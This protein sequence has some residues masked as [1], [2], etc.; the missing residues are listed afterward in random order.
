MKRTAQVA[1]VAALLALPGCDGAGPA[2]RDAGGD[3]TDGGVVLMDGG[4]ETDAGPGTDGGGTDAGDVDG[5]TGTDG[6]T[7]TDACTARTECGRYD[8]GMVDDGCGGTLEC[9]ACALGAPCGDADDCAS[10]FCLTQTDTGWNRGYCSDECFVNADCGAGFHCAFTLTNIDRVG[11]CLVSCGT[12]ADCRGPE[13]TCRQADMDG[14]RECAP[15]GSGTGAIGTPCASNAD[16]AGGDAY[17][18]LL[19]N[20]G[21]RAGLCSRTC[22]V[23]ADCGG[24][25]HCAF[26]PA[27]GGEGAC[28]PNCTADGDC[29][30][31]GYRC[32]NAD[33]DAGGVT[34]CFPSATGA[35]APG[36]ACAGVW[37]CAGGEA[38]SCFTTDIEGGYCLRECDVD[39]DCGSGAH[40]SLF[41]LCLASCTTDGDCRATGYACQ[42]LDEDSRLE[43][44]RAGTGTTAIGAPCESTAECTGGDRALCVRNRNF[45]D[46]FCLQTG[47]T[48]DGSVACP[49]GSHCSIFLDPDTGLPEP[50]GLCLPDCTTASDCRMDGYRC[51]DSADTDGV[52]ECW[53]SA[54]G[55]GAVGARCREL[56]DCAGGEAATCLYQLTVDAAGT[57]LPFPGGY[58]TRFCDTAA[59]PAGSSCVANVLCV[60]DCTMGSDCRPG[61]DYQCTMIPF[62]GPA[63]NSCWPR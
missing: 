18:C 27:S 35:G 3:G 19:E 6:G 29:R 32:L 41:G 45:A 2:P 42:D 54:T 53:P 51:Y 28:F 44:F 22:L 60:Q 10:G 40:C 16:C 62:P 58:C 49:S 59:C 63:G 11:V 61:A 21:Y 56:R 17:L 7:G 4:P 12:S 39:A 31:D 20:Q 5:A 8:C 24:G 30:A 57:I 26:V 1:V 9:G 43:C 38:G 47:C 46:G 13:Y 52:T 37:D 55:T 34:E 50:T 48:S 14:P 36:A 33:A 25:N 15:V 23:D